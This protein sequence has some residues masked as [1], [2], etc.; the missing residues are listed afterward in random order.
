M[1]PITVVKPIAEKGRRYQAI[2]EFALA[3]TRSKWDSTQQSTERHELLRMPS[4][5]SMTSIGFAGE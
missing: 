5:V 3:L 2:K 1:T 4:A